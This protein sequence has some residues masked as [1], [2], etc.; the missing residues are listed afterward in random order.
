MDSN[1]PSPNNPQAE[2]ELE[3]APKESFIQK[4]LAEIFS[5]ED[6]Q[7]DAEEELMETSSLDEETLNEKK[8][9]IVRAAIQRS[10]TERM[11]E[12]GQVS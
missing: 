7:L 2:I 10:Q 3:P 9:E 4:K 12:V 5:K 6:R 11:L 8:R 1:Y